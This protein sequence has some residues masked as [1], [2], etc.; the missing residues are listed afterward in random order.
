MERCRRTAAS[1]DQFWHEVRS[2]ESDHL[3]AV[4]AHAETEEIDLS[5]P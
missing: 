2:Y 3:D 1:N 4:A 5:Q